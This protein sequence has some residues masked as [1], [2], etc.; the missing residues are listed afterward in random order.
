MGFRRRSRLSP[1]KMLQAFQ[2]DSRSHLQEAVGDYAE[3]K[4]KYFRLVTASWKI[5]VKFAVILLMSKTVYKAS[6]KPTGSDGEKFVYVTEGTG[7]YGTKRQPYVIRPVNAPILKFRGGYSARTQPIAKFN[8]GSGKSSGDWV[9]KMEVIH[10]GI[11][12]RL[13]NET[14]DKENEKLFR[15]SIDKAIRKAL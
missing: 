9:S 5:E 1:V 13:F 6:V 4:A 11:K 15:K 3:E 2:R 12:S 10:P 7:L 14:F 8:V